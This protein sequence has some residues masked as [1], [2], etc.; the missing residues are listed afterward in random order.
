LKFT[1]ICAFLFIV[2][3]S[4]IANIQVSYADL[5]IFDETLIY[6]LEKKGQSTQIAIGTIA[7][8][9]NGTLFVNHEHNV[10]KLVDGN[11]LESYDIRPKKNATEYYDLGSYYGIAVAP[12]GTL[13]VSVNKGSYGW[14]YRVV[15]GEVFWETYVYKRDGPVKELAFRPDGELFFTDGESIYSVTE[16]E[17]FTRNSVWKEKITISSI[18]FAPDGALFTSVRYDYPN[19][20]LILKRINDR[21]QLVYVR[22]VQIDRWGIDNIAISPNGDLYFEDHDPYWGQLY[23][24]VYKSQILLENEDFYLGSVYPVIS[25]STVL[26]YFCTVGELKLNVTGLEGTQGAL[27]LPIFRRNYPDGLEVRVE[28]NG[29]PLKF[30]LTNTSAA[31]LLSFT[32]A[33]S[34]VT[35]IKIR[36]TSI[37]PRFYDGAI[38]T[39]D[40]FIMIIGILLV[41]VGLVVVYRRKTRFKPVK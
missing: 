30:N 37:S 7:F 36:L 10:Y 28:A 3:S 5:T 2:F 1:I 14:I 32:Y 17:V 11:Y 9:L 24:L 21:W 18:A 6:G 40:F 31:Y 29:R 39:P 13:Y 20:D 38:I 8:A 34:N 26:D 22:P 12:N 19:Y 23:K 35:E 33:H 41:A 27:V 16:G 4:F 15:N 25:N